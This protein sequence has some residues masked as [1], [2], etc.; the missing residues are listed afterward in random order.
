[1]NEERYHE[2]LGLRPGATRDELKTAYRDMAKVWHPD[3]FAHD[4]R[5]QSMAQEKLKEINEAYKQLTSPRPPRA[6]RPSHEAHTAY[7]DATRHART[8]HDS[9]PP[10]IIIRETPARRSFVPAV[11]AVVVIAAVTFFAATRVFTNRP[12]ATA[13]AAAAHPNPAPRIQGKTR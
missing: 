1:M 9:P 12:G 6:R 3:R 7:A 4:P 11:A 13:D 2:T 10:V 5:L 8:R